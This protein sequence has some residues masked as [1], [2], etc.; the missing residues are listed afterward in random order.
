M[1]IVINA[2]SARLGGGQTYLKNILAHLP[3]ESNFEI[4]IFAPT[5]LCL[6]EDKRIRRCN[7][8]WPTTNPLMRALWEKLILPRILSKEKVQILFCPGGIV[9]SDVPIG[10]KTVTMFRNMLPFD[11]MA[12]K[13]IPFGI[14]RV[15]NFIL[16]RLMLRSLK[17]ADLSIFISNHPRRIIEALT[18]VRNAVTIPHGIS[19]KFRTHGQT[20]QRP[21]WLPKGE[22]LLYVSRF[23]PY[24]HQ[25]EVAAAFAALPTDLRNR[26]NLIFVG[27]TDG[28]LSE[29]VIDFSRKNGLENRIWIVGSIDYT[30]LPA[31]YNHSTVNIFASSCENCPNILLEALG[32]GR[33][34]L[35]SDIMPMPEFGLDAVEYFS[36]TSS[37]SICEALIRVL[38]D[39]P[40][41]GELAAAAARRSADFDWIKASRET[42]QCVFE[43]TNK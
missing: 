12:L 38:R 20:L 13:R 27:E 30:D 23:E 24:K 19:E 11:P 39:E 37:L 21:V 25:F 16:K 6:P 2:L 9:P 18:H 1:K 32:A 29:R 10:C 43:L 22:Y 41:R 7:T 26:F 31:V 33:A 5:S 28:I 3:T 8:F 15:R 4:L 42:W 17:N 36:P 40:L 34:V 35:S 14:Q